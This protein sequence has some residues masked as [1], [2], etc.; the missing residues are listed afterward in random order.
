MEEGRDVK[1]GREGK[2]VERDGGKKKS[3]EKDEVIG[4]DVDIFIGL[5]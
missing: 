2:E 3:K 4:I 1:E 5:I